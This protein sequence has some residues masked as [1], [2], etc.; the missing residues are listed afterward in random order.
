ME[1]KLKIRLYVEID[2]W[3]KCIIGNFK[4]TFDF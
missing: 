1:Y 2:E 4:I 3:T